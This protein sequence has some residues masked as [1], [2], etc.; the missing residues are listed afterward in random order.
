MF[1]INF[2]TNSLDK[3]TV[4]SIKGYKLAKKNF[5]KLVDDGYKNVTLSDFEGQILIEI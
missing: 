5:Y 1:Y 4:L 3:F 2:R